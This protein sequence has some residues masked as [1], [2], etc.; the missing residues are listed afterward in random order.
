MARPTRIEFSGAFYYV[1]LSGKKSLFHDKQD[2]QTAEHLIGEAAK[3]YDWRIYG[4]CLLENEIHLV[5][6]TLSKTL[7]RG[8]R[9][10]SGVY[11]QEYRKRYSGDGRVVNTRFKSV[12]LDEKVWL[13]PILN[14]VMALPVKTKT[15]DFLC[16]WRWS[17][18]GAITGM[19]EV[20]EFLDMATFS[21]GA[22]Q[23]QQ[24]VLLGINQSPLKQVKKQMF[25][26]DDQFI[27]WAKNRKMQKSHTVQKPLQWF[28]ATHSNEREAMVAAY[29]SRQHTMKAIGTFF[30][31]HESTVS[32]AIKKLENTPQESIKI[33]A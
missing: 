4:W 11:A 18:Y 14:H 23:W 16:D 21:G 1:T 24:S 15:V 31:V 25:L 2:Y 13:N 8:M 10:I 5:I 33:A 30:G 29:L 22:Y 7:S 27:E 12:L 19:Q 32:R 9:H 3:R 28:K 26:G 20:P 17:S 6:E